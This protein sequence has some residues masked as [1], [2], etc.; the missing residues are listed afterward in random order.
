MAPGL[1]GVLDGAGV[2]EEQNV[3]LRILKKTANAVPFQL[4]SVL[5]RVATA[6]AGSDQRGLSSHEGSGWE[7]HEAQ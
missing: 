4:G 1:G 7:T 2:Q 6:A 3:R 5:A